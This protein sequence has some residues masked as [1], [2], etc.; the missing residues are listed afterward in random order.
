MSF[1]VQAGLNTFILAFVA[2]FKGYDEAPAAFLGF[3]AYRSK[4]VT[5]TAGATLFD[6]SRSR[7]KTQRVHILLDPFEWAALGLPIDPALKVCVTACVAR[8]V[9]WQDTAGGRVAHVGKQL[10]WRNV[11]FKNTDAANEYMSLVDSE[12]KH[13]LLE[14]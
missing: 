11:L 3:I 1:T 13:I 4:V 14:D 10:E 7:A 6:T 9:Q 8:D 12:T 2:P 5:T